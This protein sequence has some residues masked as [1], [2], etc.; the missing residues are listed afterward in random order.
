LSNAGPIG[1]TL[2]ALEQRLAHV[3]EN[4]KTP[5]LRE[6]FLLANRFRERR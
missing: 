6:D 4:L 5:E 2:L 3:R 1:E